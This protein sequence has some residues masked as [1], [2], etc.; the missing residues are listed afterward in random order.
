MQVIILFL[1]INIAIVSGL[2]CDEILEFPQ[3][4]KLTKEDLESMQ[5]KDIVQCLVH[6]GREQL[7]R[8]E[9]EFIW[10]SIIKFHEGIINVP[11]KVLSVLHW[12]TIAITPEEY[13]NL[14]LNNIDV[15]QNFGLN[16]NLNEAQL[17]AIA[18]RV[19]EDFAGKEPEDYTYYDLTAIRQ[20]LCAYNKS[21][22]ERIPPSSYRE[23]AL[24]IGKLE[25]CGPE[26]M[27]GFATLAVQK[28]AFGPLRNWTEDTVKIIGKVANYLPK[29]FLNKFSISVNPV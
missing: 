8:P 11:D 16:Y 7:P 5:P 18:N 3:D 27:S 15:V 24:L 2:T 25:K 28:R 6:L 13:A 23:A 12:I 10:K 21:E 1:F 9:A 14:T 17:S 19:R 26:A 4:K 22:I 20:I 29:E